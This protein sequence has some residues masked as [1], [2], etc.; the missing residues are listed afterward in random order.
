MPGR[1]QIRCKTTRLSQH[2]RDECE[3]SNQ[4]NKLTVDPAI[5]LYISQRN[6]REIHSICI[7]KSNQPQKEYTAASGCRAQAATGSSMELTLG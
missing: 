2:R 5:L 4:H 1:M 3:G 7:E 6:M